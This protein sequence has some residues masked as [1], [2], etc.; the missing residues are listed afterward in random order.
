ME[1]PSN[2]SRFLQKLLCP[3]FPN[4]TDDFWPKNDPHQY[5]SFLQDEAS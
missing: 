3:S 4:L 1:K 5:V 2:H